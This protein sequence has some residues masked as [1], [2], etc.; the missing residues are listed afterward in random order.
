MQTDD[1]D[2]AAQGPRDHV[3]KVLSLDGSPSYLKES[4]VG[5]RCFRTTEDMSEALRCTKA[6]A[7]EMAD[8]LNFASVHVRVAERLR[9]APKLLTA[10]VLLTVTTA[11]GYSSA[12]IGPDGIT[13]TGDTHLPRSPS[14]RA[15]L[16][17][18]IVGLV[19]RG[20]QDPKMLLRV[21]VPASLR[22]ACKGSDADKA[23]EE[24]ATRLRGLNLAVFVTHCDAPA[25]APVAPVLP[26]D[27]DERA[28]VLL[29]AS[30]VLR[31]HSF[32]DPSP[33]SEGGWV[34]GG[35]RGATMAE[36]VEARAAYLLSGEEEG[37][38]LAELADRRQGA[39][40]YQERLATYEAALA[41][42]RA[43]VLT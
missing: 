13:L 40:M 20:T 30:K 34:A 16:Q 9:L 31:H 37:K 18:A 8:G 36:A 14:K 7:D 12:T 26:T 25:P 5:R 23:M 28:R 1:H 42:L 10:P 32:S 15:P 43:A 3:V 11:D 6:E 29:A 33:H 35:C 4:P 27:P 39:A 17:A 41:T 24:M 22:I 2:A 21:D 19:D 38:I